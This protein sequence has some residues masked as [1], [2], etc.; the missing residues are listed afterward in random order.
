[1][2]K[3]TL[4][5]F[6][7]LIFQI[8]FTQDFLKGPKAKN[9]SFAKSKTS[10]TSLVFYSNPERPKGVESKKFKIWNSESSKVQVR[11]RKVINNPKGL[12]AKNRKVWEEEEIDVDS[13]AA[14]ELPKSM[15]P[16]KSWWH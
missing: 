3:L 8:G 2:K 7:L 15:R 10:Q 9:I 16:K 11:T 12:K 6:A 14:Y 1:M 5:L 4:L 13:K